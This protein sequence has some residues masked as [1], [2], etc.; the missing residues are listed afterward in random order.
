M[1][2]RFEK[3]HEAS[4]V[5][6][7]ESMWKDKQTYLEVSYEYMDRYWYEDKYYNSNYVF[8]VSDD[9]HGTINGFI[10]GEIHESEIEIV[11]LFVHPVFRR[12]NIAS[13]LK[14]KVLKFAELIGK[15]EVIAYNLHSNERSLGMNNKIGHVIEPIDEYYYKSVYIIAKVLNK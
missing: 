4:F 8:F 10:V 7:I 3:K 13:G 6:L 12:R 1:I 14:R 11:F 15:D 5:N 9:K 2:S